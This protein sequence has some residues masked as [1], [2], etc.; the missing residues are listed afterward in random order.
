MQN[1]LFA[2]AQVVP[3]SGVIAGEVTAGNPAAINKNAFFHSVQTHVRW[4]GRQRLK[5]DG[6]TEAG[7]VI[8]IGPNGDSNGR[9]WNARLLRLLKLLNNLS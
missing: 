7:Y 8:L 2:Q 5:G 9:R 3:R 1:G 4:A 6:H